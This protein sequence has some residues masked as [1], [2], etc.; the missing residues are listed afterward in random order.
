MC[1]PRPAHLGRNRADPGADSQGDTGRSPHLGPFPQAAWRDRRRAEGL[2]GCT[3]LETHWQLGFEAVTPTDPHCP[4]AP[5]G[6]CGV[7]DVRSPGPGGLPP[8]RNKG[9]PLRCWGSQT[10]NTTLLGACK[11]PEGVCRQSSPGLRA[12]TLALSGR[13]EGGGHSALSAGAL[14]RHVSWDGVSWVHVA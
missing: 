11:G 2:I 13:A 3:Q 7:C 8:C 14:L 5:G 1:V 10:S 9:S 12:Q 4:P 6:D